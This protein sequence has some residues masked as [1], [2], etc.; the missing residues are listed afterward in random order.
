ML[1]ILSMLSHSPLERVPQHACLRHWSPFFSLQRIPLCVHLDCLTVLL[2]RN[3]DGSSQQLSPGWAQHLCHPMGPW[4]VQSPLPLGI[5]GEGTALPRVSGG[6]RQCQDE[7]SDLLVIFYLWAGVRKD[8]WGPGEVLRRGKEKGIE[9]VGLN[10]PAF[11]D[12]SWT[13]SVPG[14]RASKCCA[15]GQ[16]FDI[17]DDRTLEFLNSEEPDISFCTPLIL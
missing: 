3:W 2:G 10:F 1:S 16:V 4:S 9:A 11:P 7:N 5:M 12:F 8:I 15:S 17:G 14:K 13:H 6:L